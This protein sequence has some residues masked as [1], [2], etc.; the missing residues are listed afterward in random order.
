MA[1]IVAAGPSCGRD[2]RREANE[3]D[4][5]LKFEA[6]RGLCRLVAAVA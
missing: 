4:I 3:D 6:D 5:L 2:A 1:P